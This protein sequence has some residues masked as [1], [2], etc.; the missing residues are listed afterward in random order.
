MNLQLKNFRCYR[1]KTIEIPSG[2]LLIS[3]DSGAG[4]STIFAAIYYAYFGTVRQP[5][6]HG[7]TS[8]CVKL[9]DENLDLSIK[10]TSH[11]NSLIVVHEGK[12]YGDNAAQSIINKIIGLTADEFRLSS[13]F[14]QQNHSSILS[15]PPQK[16]LSFANTIAFDTEDNEAIKLKIKERVVEIMDIKKKQ[17]AQLELLTAQ[18]EEYNVSGAEEHDEN[19][20]GTLEDA[21]KE[22]DSIKTDLFQLRSLFK[23]KYSLLETMRIDENNMKKSKE[24][25]IKIRA[26]LEQWKSLVPSGE[27]YTEEHLKTLEAEATKFRTL[28]KHLETQMAAD[29]YITEYK[30]AKAEFLKKTEEDINN[31]ETDLSQID[32]DQ[33]EKTIEQQDQLLIEY[34]QWKRKN[35]ECKESKNNA[36]KKL[37]DIKKEFKVLT[38]ASSPKSH[39]KFVDKIDQTIKS[40]SS[41]IDRKTALYNSAFSLSCPGCGKM[42][43]YNEEEYTLDII[44][45][46]AEDIDT[47]NLEKEIEKLDELRETL[48]KLHESAKN[49][50][51]VWNISPCKWTKKQPMDESTINKLKETLKEYYA[52]SDLVKS[53]KNTISQKIIPKEI[54]RYKELAQ[55]KLEWIPKDVSSTESLDEIIDKIKKLEEVISTEWKRK[56]DYDNTMREIRKKK[57]ELDKYDSLIFRSNDKKIKKISTDLETINI[58]IDDASIK[59]EAAQ[60]RVDILIRHEMKSE[61]LKMARKIRKRKEQITEEYQKTEKMCLG[62]IGLEKASKEAEFIA[63]EE[64]ISSINSHAKFYLDQM[65]ED[66]MSAWL[67]VNYETKHKKIMACPKLSVVINYGGNQYNSIDELSGGEKQRCNLCFLLAVN[68]ILGS[69]ILML[70]ECLNNLNSDMNTRVIKCIKELCSQKHV[71]VI[72]HE[73]ISGLFDDNILYV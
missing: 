2:F 36:S 3:G 25:A 56:G 63:L 47:D 50:T 60:K 13:Y 44:D 59:L 68:D 11:P 7:E 34:N 48:E 27:I 39:S 9:D 26:E 10:R 46:P 38:S 53:H 70:D 20:D 54:K 21:E 14:D 19:S 33:L 32:V 58:K 31:L 29:E 43:Q 62:M 55:A 64:T 65:F 6:T 1:E 16:Q 5:Y 57:F 41:D 51:E 30:R 42:L 73:A 23:K 8:C 37:T 66:P 40:I 28:K 67:Q 72:S 61:S 17:E 49:L 35:G 18:L 12:E 24:K 22:R 69:K 52:K 45:K 71:L 4:K 15:M